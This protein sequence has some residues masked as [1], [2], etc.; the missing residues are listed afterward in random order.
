MFSKS[1]HFLTVRHVLQCFDILHL[2]YWICLNI[3]DY[4]N[5]FITNAVNT[6]KVENFLV[7]TLFGYIFKVF[8]LFIFFIHSVVI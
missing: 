5:F 1:L 4:I 7:R 8:I 3:L 6:A 2:S